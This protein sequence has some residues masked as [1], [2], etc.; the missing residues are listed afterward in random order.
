MNL[1]GES[2]EDTDLLLDLAC[3]LTLLLLAGERDKPATQYR[4]CGIHPLTTHCDTCRCSVATGPLCD[5]VNLSSNKIK[6]L[7]C[8]PLWSTCLLFWLQA[9]C[10]AA[11]PCTWYM[12]SASAIINWREH[13]SP[14]RY[15]LALHSRIACSTII[16][17]CLPLDSSK[18][19]ASC[20]DRGVHLCCHPVYGL[21]RC[22]THIACH[23][24]L[25]W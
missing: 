24:K 18:I 12:Y 7:W 10:G 8:I 17:Q 19:K 1:L 11:S 20:L 13:Q 4:E 23:R 25:P 21:C 22:C 9:H 5:D 6:T 16:P 3:Q 2:R 14:V 15:L